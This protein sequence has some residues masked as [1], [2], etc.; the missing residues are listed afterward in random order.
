MDN[1]LTIDLDNQYVTSS[2]SDK[3]IYVFDFFRNLRSQFLNLGLLPP[4][5]RA[6][7]PLDEDNYC[8]VLI[9][10]RPQ[11]RTIVLED[12]HKGREPKVYHLN[13]PWHSYIL[14]LN[15]YKNSNSIVLVQSF[16]YFHHRQIQSELDLNSNFLCVPWIPNVF[17]HGTICLGDYTMEGATYKPYEFIDLYHDFGQAFWSTTFN[18]DVHEVA[19]AYLT[20]WSKLSSFPKIKSNCDFQSYVID[21]GD[22]YDEDECSCS[23]HQT[24]LNQML[25]RASV[26]TLDQVCNEDLMIKT[27]PYV[28]PGYNPLNIK[29]GLSDQLNRPISLMD[30]FKAAKP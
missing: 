6:I 23:Q 3:S 9:E 14:E 30:L 26:F 5:V 8:H 15:Y 17:C 25:E 13:L 11:Q 27:N 20:A 22:Y 28:Y 1:V 7:S 29:D 10:N 24:Q 4:V 21:E 19:S 12:I 2:L 18:N 16:L